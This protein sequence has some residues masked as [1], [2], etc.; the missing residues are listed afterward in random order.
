M[1]IYKLNILCRVDKAIKRKLKNFE[2]LAL[3]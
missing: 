3:Y 1:L 2:P